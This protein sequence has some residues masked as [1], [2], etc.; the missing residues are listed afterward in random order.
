MENA[1]LVWV[2]EN[3]G[4]SQQQAA[5]LMGV[6]RRTFSR[7]ETGA[8]KMPTHKWNAFL[9]KVNTPA[10]AIPKIKTLPDE[11][12]LADVVPADWHGLSLF[13]DD[14]TEE[15][16]EP[17]V[18]HVVKQNGPMEQEDIIAAS[19]QLASAHDA[20]KAIADGIR[21]GLYFRKGN[22]IGITPK[23][24]EWANGLDLIG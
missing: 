5:E 6:D 22:R 19:L 12:P 10:G 21:D 7:W 17:L 1:D 3:S 11:H 15:M 13:S 14:W 16:F 4:L 8:V 2:R 18:L 20:H 23:G 24:R 9:A